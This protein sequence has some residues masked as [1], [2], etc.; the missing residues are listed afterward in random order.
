M[1]EELEALVARFNAKVETDPRLREELQG[2]TRTVVLDLKDGSQFHFVLKDAHVDGVR[3]GGAEKPDLV[4]ISDKET[5]SGLL[6][7]KI[8]PF[9]AYATGKLRVKG[10]IEDLM[11]FRKFF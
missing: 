6:A 2:L 10:D 1:R 4:I 9:K 7:G 8:G 5:L 3:D 11:R